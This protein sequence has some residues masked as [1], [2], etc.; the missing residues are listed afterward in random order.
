MNN[1][2]TTTT[3]VVSVPVEKTTAPMQRMLQEM[4]LA[5]RLDTYT[6]TFKQGNRSITDVSA[7]GVNKLAVAAGISIDEVEIVDETDEYVTVKATAVNADGTTHCGLVREPKAV[8]GRINPYA[9][10][11]ATTKAQRNAKK[12]LLPMSEIK[13]IITRHGREVVRDS[14]Q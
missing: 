2:D 13:D 10:Q 11:T 3:E 9:I 12:G 5:E 7:D 14:G 4:E 1:H 6:Y 8:N